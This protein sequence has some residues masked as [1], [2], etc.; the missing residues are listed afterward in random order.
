MKAIKRTLLLVIPATLFLTGCLS[1]GRNETEVYVPDSPQGSR[2]TVVKDQIPAE[3]TRKI[4]V[5]QQY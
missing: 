1:H 2:T 3:G 5:V 4:P